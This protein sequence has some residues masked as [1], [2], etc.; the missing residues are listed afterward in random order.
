MPPAPESTR[1]RPRCPFTSTSTC[2]ARAPLFEYTEVWETT[3]TGTLRG[4]P[5]VHVARTAGGCRSA[6]VTAA[7]AS[8]FVILKIRFESPSRN[9]ET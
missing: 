1:K 3:L 4:S 2:T 8:N 9:A 6:S 5:K 7:F